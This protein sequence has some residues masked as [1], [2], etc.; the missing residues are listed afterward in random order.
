MPVPRVSVGVYVLAEAEAGAGFAQIELN[1]PV[2]E[3]MADPLKAVESM[4][5]PSAEQL[6]AVLAK[7]PVIGETVGPLCGALN[8]QILLAIL[9]VGSLLGMMIFGFTPL[10]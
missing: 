7:A 2:A 8:G 9:V 1:F 6:K 5:G 10:V 3:L 4:F